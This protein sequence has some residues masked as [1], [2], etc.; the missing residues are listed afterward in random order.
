MR[1]KREGLRRLGEA[2]DHEAGLTS[3]EKTGE[4]EGSQL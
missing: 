3:S 2:S 1:A 4:E